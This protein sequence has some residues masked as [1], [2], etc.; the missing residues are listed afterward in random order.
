MCFLHSIHLYNPIFSSVSIT[1]CSY[2]TCPSICTKMS[3]SA[4][5][6][7]AHF[8]RR[9]AHL[10]RWKKASSFRL[11]VG[12]LL[13]NQTTIGEAPIAKN[14]IYYVNVGIPHMPRISPNLWAIH[15]A[16]QGFQQILSYTNSNALSIASISA[17]SCTIHWKSF[18]P[19]ATSKIEL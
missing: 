18:L 6:L 8:H 9:V 2:L 4:H 3:I 13:T 5:R 16:L 15:L 10:Y 19:G 12:G 11:K 1:F 17:L 7:L 14:H